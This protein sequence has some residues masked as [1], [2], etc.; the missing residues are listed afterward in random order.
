M[1][2]GMREG[3]TISLADVLERAKLKATLKPVTL[4]LPGGD[5]G[6]IATAR[7]LAEEKG[8]GY[9][10]YIKILLHESLR[11]EVARQARASRK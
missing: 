3:K 10:T 6:D 7:R 8:I 5:G 9:Q 2:Q 4:R 1:I 11:S